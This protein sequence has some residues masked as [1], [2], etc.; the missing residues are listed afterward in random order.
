[1]AVL[2]ATKIGDR[3]AVGRYFEQTFEVALSGTNPA[4]EWIVTGFDEVVSVVG[5]AVIGTAGLADVPAFKYNLAG[6]GGAATPG[7][8][9]M[10]S[11]TAQTIHV[12]VR[13]KGV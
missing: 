9:G 6:T 2:S 10:E 5:F 13:G 12:T 7:A 8:L 11:V 3:I 1:M 4:D